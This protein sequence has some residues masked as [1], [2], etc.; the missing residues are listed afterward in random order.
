VRRAR[1][2]TAAIDTRHAA[3][4][5]CFGGVDGRNRAARF[6][7]NVP[8]AKSVI[9]AYNPAVPGGATERRDDRH[10][11]GGVREPEF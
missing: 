8:R 3:S 11:A 10:L 2:S 9:S 1:A 7:R 4:R 6:E 5:V